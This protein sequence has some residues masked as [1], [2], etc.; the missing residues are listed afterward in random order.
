MKNKSHTL[1]ALLSGAALFSVVAASCV[2]TKIF[3]SQSGSS[4]EQSTSSSETSSSQSSASSS[5]SSSSVA[6]DGK[7]SKI[8]VKYTM[9]KIDETYAP[10]LGD[11]KLLMIPIKLKGTSTYS[12][13]ERVLNTL[14]TMTFGTDEP[15]SLVNYYKRASLGR[16]NITGEVAGTMTSMYQSPDYTEKDFENGTEATYEKLFDLLQKAVNWAGTTYGLDLDSYDTNDDG[17]I[18]SVHFVING[19]D[20]NDWGTNALWP[21]MYQTSFGAGTLKAPNVHTYSVTNLGHVESD[22]IT[23]IHEQ[24][25]IF[26]LD[27]YYN[28]GAQSASTESAYLRFPDYLGGLD[29]QNNN[30]M[31]WNGFSKMSAGWVDPIV[32][33]ASAKTTRVTLK[34]SATS[35]DVLILGNDWNGTAFDEY[36]MMELFTDAGNN[37]YFWDD[38]TYSLGQGGVKV[39]HVDA[40]LW[41]YN[42]ESTYAQGGLV[43]D[44]TTSTYKN[45]WFACTNS[46]GSEYGQKLSQFKNMP[47]IQVLQRDNKNTFGST[48][49]QSKKN[50]TLKEADLFKTGDT[51]T[52]GSHAGYTDY[53]ANFFAKKTTMDDGTT[54]PYGIKFV[55][56]TPEEATL[57]IT[58]F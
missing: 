39:Y 40:R 31:D 8:P 51:F 54:F 25:H 17:F 45:H 26:G 11:Q 28:Y 2:N 29:M 13:S 56:V 35:G 27:D 38:V 6:A 44:L 53:G 16:I 47:L 55:S 41:G 58:R 30:T 18:D 19:T 33:D 43:D 57:E 20:N 52:I 1:L 37:S 15:M 9:N 50:R 32:I 22:A 5:N 49:Y 21:H 14:K 48:A 12:F 23:T 7:F 4:E 46:T 3:N 42:S 36:V 34:P 10:T 24:G